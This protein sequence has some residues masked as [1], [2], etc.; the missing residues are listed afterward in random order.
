MWHYDLPDVNL[1]LENPIQKEAWQK[2]VYKKVRDF[3][4]QKILDVACTYS[5]LKH[6]S[7]EG[8]TP[9]RIH[10]LL[11]LETS[12][13]TDINRIRLKLKMLVGEY[14]LQTN[15]AAFNQNEFKP[16]CLL[17]DNEEETL[18]HFLLHCKSLDTVRLPVLND[19]SHELMHTLKKD[20]QSYDDH[21]KISIILDCTH[22]VKDKYN[23]KRV[24]ELLSTL[25]FHCR[26]LTFL[27][28]NM[29]YR[30]LHNISTRKR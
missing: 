11:A 26:R 4:K 12:S 28:H 14:V 6:L 19:V 1:L 17:C 30:L 3:W 29:R 7:F 25:E 13:P 15:R 8:F 5:S 22:L 24:L 20:F 10:P 2:Q 21:D 23:Q 9:G 18:A 27:L 16:I